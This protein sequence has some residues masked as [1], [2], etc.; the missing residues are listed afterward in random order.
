MHLLAMGLGETRRH[1]AL[2]RHPA[3]ACGEWARTDGT[4]VHGGSIPAA[5]GRC[6]G[7]GFDGYC[8][9]SL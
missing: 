5:A 3:I 1:D 7:E 6:K 9:V 4:E 8:T 2:R